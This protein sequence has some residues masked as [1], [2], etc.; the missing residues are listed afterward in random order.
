[1]YQEILPNWEK[2]FKEKLCVNGPIE[3]FGA[4]EYAQL[5]AFSI[6]ALL[7]M[8]IYVKDEFWG[9][10]SFDDYH[11]KRVFSEMEIYILRSW[12]L[13]VVGAFQRNEITQGMYHTLN[14]LEAIIS[15]YKGIIWSVDT[16]GIVTTFSGQFVTKMGMKPSFFEGKKLELVQQ[17]SRYL[18]IIDQVEQTFR[19]SPQQWTSDINDRIFH[20][21]TMPI[22]DP[23]GNIT[24]V[25]GS[26]D[27][28]TEFLKL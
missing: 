4:P 3:N 23:N 12:A 16:A 14:K 25:V 2:L 9:F 6:Q 17:K 22:Y 7:A 28:V 8:P 27:E 21:A 5:G 19:G 1:V 18:D 20:S 11:H 15:N 13:L 10:I 24:G 26:T